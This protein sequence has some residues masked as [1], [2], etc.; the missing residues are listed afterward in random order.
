MLGSVFLSWLQGRGA[1]AFHLV[2]VLSITLGDVIIPWLIPLI[3]S[4]NV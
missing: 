3:L 2:L 4:L 1:S